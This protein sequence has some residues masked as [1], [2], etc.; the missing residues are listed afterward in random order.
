[1]NTISWLRGYIYGAKLQLE[2]YAYDIDSSLDKFLECA[3]AVYID[4]ELSDENLPLA[5]VDY[6]DSNEGELFK[7]EWYHDPGDASVGITRL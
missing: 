7:V 5:L 4:P 1:M 6:A 2:Q 3:H